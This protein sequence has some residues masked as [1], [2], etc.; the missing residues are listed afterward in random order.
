[1]R[2][3]SKIIQIPT[4][5]ARAIGQAEAARLDQVRRVIE[6]RSEHEAWARTLYY[7]WAYRVGS[8]QAWEDLMVD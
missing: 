6:K 4:A 7:V 3:Q 2:E 1:M 5:R 8:A